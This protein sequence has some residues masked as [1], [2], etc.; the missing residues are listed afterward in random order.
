METTTYNASSAFFPSPY[1]KAAIVVIDGIGEWAC[2]TVGYGE[3]NKI[4]LIINI[5]ILYF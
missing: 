1:K 3:S 2:T 5:L 4:N